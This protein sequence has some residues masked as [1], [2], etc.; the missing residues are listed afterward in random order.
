MCPEGRRRIIDM[1]DAIMR[2]AIKSLIS[3]RNCYFFYFF[4]FKEKHLRIGFLF[5]FSVAIFGNRRCKTHPDLIQ[6]MHHISPSHLL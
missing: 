6:I 5:F 3:K 4:F 2:F 1:S